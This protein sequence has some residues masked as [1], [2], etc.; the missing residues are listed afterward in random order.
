[1]VDAELWIVWQ[2][3]VATAS[4]QRWSSTGKAKS[5]AW[6][7]KD[8]PVLIAINNQSGTECSLRQ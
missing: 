7:I 3:K 5:E 1:M 6:T 8:Y 2:Y 4:R